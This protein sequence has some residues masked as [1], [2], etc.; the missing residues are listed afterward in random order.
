MSFNIVRLRIYIVESARTDNQNII[1]LN[2]QR[3]SKFHSIQPIFNLPILLF[4]GILMLLAG[5]AQAQTPVTNIENATGDSVFI[6]FEDGALLSLGEFNTGVIPTEG[7]GTR[8]MWYPAKA[9]FRSGIVDGIQWDDANIGPWSIAMGYN[10]TARGTGSTAL[11]GGTTASGFFSTAMGAS[12]TAVS[13]N[14]M[15]I[16]AYNS[17]NSTSDNTLFVAGNGEAGTPSDALV[18]DQDA[19]LVVNGD[20]GTGV[21]PTEGAGA[22]M[23]WY[24]AKAAF[25]VGHVNGDQWDDVNIGYYSTAMGTGATAEGD[26]ST[27]MGMYTTA[28]GEAS[29]AMGYGTTASGSHLATR[30]ASTAMGRYTTASGETSTAMGDRTTASASYS[31]AMGSNTTASASSSTAMGRNT[32]AATYSSL[33]TGKYN[34][35]N[36]SNDGSLFVVGNGTYST[37]SDALVLDDTGDM[38]IAGTLTESSD[39]RLK[40]NIAELKDGAL[41]RL[42][43]ITPSTFE[44]KNQK[45]HPAGPQIG[46]IAQ[47]V[48]KQFPELVSE[49][50]NGYLSVSYSKFTAVLL[51]GVQEQ[52]TLINEQ[53]DKIKQLEEKVNRIDKLQAE[54]AGLKSQNSQQAGYYLPISA[55]LL[56]LL[57]GSGW[58]WK[59][60]NEGLLKA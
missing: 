15:S 50:S 12:T 41:G 28:S 21:I 31:T 53:K 10:T 4:G 8:M 55:F 25:R 24:P 47:E 13:D 58:V 32:T 38:T 48:Q 3:V 40:T 6:S 16:G 23:M 54:V 51:K 1:L 42:A 26:Y 60:K 44:F 45:T 39:R 18:L 2:M 14:S 29:T 35:A 27:A 33:S 30:G 20:F 22:R 11:G 37:P 34:S 46:L 59:Y 56:L 57:V 17:A 49:A 43:T 36:N 9:A 19:G 7:A 5:T 52:Q